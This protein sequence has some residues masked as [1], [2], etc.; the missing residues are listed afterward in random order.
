L[1]E[2]TKDVEFK[3]PVANICKVQRVNKNWVLQNKTQ[4]M[5][6][7]T[8]NMEILPIEIGERINSPCGWISTCE[9]YPVFTMLG[10]VC[11]VLIGF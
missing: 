8:W 10:S 2:D 9:I 5:L 4:V 1:T 6:G 3:R 7:S 11:S